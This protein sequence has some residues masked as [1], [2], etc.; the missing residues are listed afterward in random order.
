MTD[1]RNLLCLHYEFSKK[2]KLIKIMYFIKLAA[3]NFLNNLLGCILLHAYFYFNP[4]V[5]FVILKIFKKI[6]FANLAFVNFKCL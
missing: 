3:G 6:E 5:G 2:L 1:E 4:Y